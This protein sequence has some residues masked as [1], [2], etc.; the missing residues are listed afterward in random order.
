MNVLYVVF[1]L[2]L[3]LSGVAVVAFLW[4]TRRG[5]FDDLTTPALRILTD[6]QKASKPG[7]PFP[8]AS[9]RAALRPQTR[10]TARDRASE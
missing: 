7:S 10:P 6:E 2:A 4:A 8:S 3:S 9:P 5:Q 1:P